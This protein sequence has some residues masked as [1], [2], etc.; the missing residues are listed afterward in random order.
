M[1]EI[2]D[3]FVIGAGSGGVRAARIA[4]MHGAKVGIAEKSRFGGT[5]VIRGCVPKKLLVYAS[6]FAE[7]F[8]VAESFG[9]GKVAA[10]FDWPTLI[11]NKNKEIARLEGLYLEGLQK[12][13]VTTFHEE[14]SFENATTLR[15]SS[16][17]IIEAK[18]ILIATGGKPSRAQFS[19]AE[20]AMV[21]DDILELKRQ[22]KHL[23]VVGGGYIGIEFA[24][25]FAGLGSKVSIINRGASILRGF[26]SETVQ[27]L[28][29][30][31]QKRGIFI[32]YHAELKT[33]SRNG[34]GL[35]AELTSGDIL[36]C[37]DV[38]LAT[39]RTAN[40]ETLHLDAVDVK[41]NDKGAIIVNEKS[42][43]S[44]PNIYAVGDVTGHIALTPVA[45]REGH[46]LADTLFGNK[47]WQADL[48]TIPSA[49]FSTPELGSVGL[50]EEQA[51]QRFKNI[52]IFCTRFRPMKTAMAQM[53]EKTFMKL[54][55]DADTDIVLGA[56]M[57]GEGAA[58]MVQ[59]LALP[60][61]LKAKKAD[62]D[63]TMALHPSSAE[64]WLTMRMPKALLPAKDIKTEVRRS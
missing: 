17:K 21:S 1:A 3:F 42:Q 15:L 11:A 56:H 36:E 18:H 2:F 63:A 26:D 7:D 10:S 52:K 4:A 12:T 22:P 37:D 61:R 46:A 49:V 20:L 16:G 45:I 6:R 57:I 48:A 62:F 40:T 14:A 60:L 8:E 41:T 38:L 35:R 24:C 44:I 33:L 9:W 25:V 58:E 23:V 64:E 43:T 32:H 34:A 51:H 5:C 29:A 55:V 13:G 47:T 54:V 59:L 28:T 53:H 50:S 19:G 30:A 31:L 27:E 39:G